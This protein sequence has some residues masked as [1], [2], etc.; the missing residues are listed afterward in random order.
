MEKQAQRE[1]PQVLQSPGPP[2]LDLQNV[3]PPPSCRGWCCYSA[4]NPVLLVLVGRSPSGKWE[5]AT[6]ASGLPPILSVI[7][8]KPNLP[9]FPHL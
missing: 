7:Y 3:K 4:F 2:H 8:S 6:G 9:Q 1:T 5:A